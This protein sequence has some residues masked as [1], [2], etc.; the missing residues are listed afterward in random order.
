MK[1]IMKKYTQK[2]T[3]MTSKENK[4]LVR[5]IFTEIGKGNHE[6]F[7]NAVAEDFSITCIG[8][9]PISGTYKGIKEVSEKFIG[10]VMS[11]FKTPPRVVV[12][13]IIAEDDFVVVVAH[14]D[15]GI[16]KNGHAYNNTY[17]HV[18]R[19]QDGKIVESTEYLDTALVNAAGLGRF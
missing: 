2:T 16:T 18:M 6:P 3:P 7:L 9:T 12:D 19:L 10:P 11:S 13:R 1:K 17:C 8:T 5:H 4:E 14:G 15:G